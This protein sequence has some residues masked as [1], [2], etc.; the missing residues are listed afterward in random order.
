MS[1]KCQNLKIELC[2]A[3]VTVFFEW[4][5]ELVDTNNSINID[6]VEMQAIAN[7]VASME[8]ILIFPFDEDYKE[9]LELMRKKV[10]LR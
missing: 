6:S 5:S 8:K 10:E 3:D 9:H 4:A 7:I 2:E 1:D